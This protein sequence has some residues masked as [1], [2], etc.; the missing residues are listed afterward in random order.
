MS[1][2]STS[3]KLSDKLRYP[4]FLRTV[5]SDKHQTQAL[6]KLMNHYGWNWVGLLY[7]DGEYG[8]G[9]FESFLN[10]PAASNVCL[11]YQEM[12][13]NYE[14]SFSLKHIRRVSQQIISSSAQVVVLILRA[15][16][17][18]ELFMEMI[19]T[20]TTRTWISSDTWSQS[21]LISK[22]EG[23]N[24]VGDILGLT[25]I[26]HKSQSF[27]NYLT[28]LTVTPGGYNNFIKDYKNLRFNCTPECFSNTPPPHC[29]P[30]ELLKFKSPNACNLEDPQ[31]QNDDYLVKCLDTSRAQATREAVWAVAYALQ[32]LLKC[33]NTVCLGETNFPPWKVN[34]FPD[35]TF[36]FFN[37]N[38]ILINWHL[39][40]TSQLLKELKK[41]WFD[42][43]NQ[44]LSFDQDGG[45]VTGYDLI[46]WEVDGKHRRYQKIG[47]YTVLEK[48]IKL[49]V[50]NAIWSSTGNTT[51]KTIH[52]SR[53]YR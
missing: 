51:V 37:G 21:S 10:E 47:K 27:D 25:F 8:K 41:V 23:I 32:K 36:F 28:N 9:A 26:S 44:T 35:K 11:A 45:F 30:P 12:L 53:R 49:T 20:K 33:N 2:T 18:K 22:M 16:L 3:P 5:P 15:E 39:S 1:S 42:F 34:P 19:R 50:Q 24:M 6:A 31:N 14:N 17:V 4:V 7:E 38:Q 48:Q 52:S 13:P 29:P 43:D 40:L 46:R